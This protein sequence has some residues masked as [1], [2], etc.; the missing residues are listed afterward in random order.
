MLQPPVQILQ[1]MKARWEAEKS[2]RLRSTGVFIPFSQIHI[3]PD[4]IE[5]QP[6]KQTRR[7]GVG[8]MQKSPH[9][10]SHHQRVTSA[11]IKAQMAFYRTTTLCPSRSW[12]LGGNL[13]EKTRG[14]I[15]ESTKRDAHSLPNAAHHPSN[16]LRTDLNAA[17][18]TNH[19]RRACI[20]GVRTAQKASMV[21]NVP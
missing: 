7:T 6:S 1:A 16:K 5:R 18:H 14:K 4:L 17:K 21:A 8:A 9:V 13:R 15:W 12:K 19:L 10:M 2:E 11:E 3:A 20:H